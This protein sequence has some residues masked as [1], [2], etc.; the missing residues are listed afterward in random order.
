MCNSN[1][2][3]E[4]HLGLKV[5]LTNLLNKTTIVEDENTEEF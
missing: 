3:K 4:N 5:H 1:S 2:A